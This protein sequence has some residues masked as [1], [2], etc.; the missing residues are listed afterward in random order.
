MDEA[1]LVTTLSELIALPSVGGTPAEAEIQHLLAERLTALGLAVDRWPIDLA[2]LRARP[3]FPGEE[4]ERTQAWGLVGMHRPQERPALIL[5]GHVDVVPPGDLSRWT[6]GPYA[7]TVR[8]GRVVGRGACDMKGGV[9]AILGAV[10]AALSSGA[11]V[12]PFAVHFVVGEEDG[13]L[14]AYATLARGH[15]GDACVIPEPTSLRLVTANAGSLTFRIDVPGQATH[16]STRYEGH[17]AIDAYLPI[18]SALAALEQ[19]R[20]AHPEPPLRDYP[21][22]YPLSVGRLQAGDW[23]SSVPDRL[24][25]EGRYG[26]RIGEDPAAA[27]AELEAAVAE[28]AAGEPYLREHPPRVTWPGGVFRGGQ[29]PP[30][31]SLEAPV[32][33]AHRQVT[34]RD[35]GPARGV[36][37]GSDLRLYAGAGIPTLHYGPGSP[38]EAHGPDEW[39]PIDELVT[40]AEVL[41]RLLRSRY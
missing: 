27:R 5:Q 17:S 30:G 8:D 26:V 11:E 41:T 34:G 16:G 28:A 19:R 1:G 13:G 35:I 23:P 9:A 12:P 15:T 38:R 22:A 25:A 39:V 21:I 18:H 33:D 7:P 20:N 2:G 31:S 36:S 32:G 29:L 24:V 4:V 6:G 14:G 3:D 37:Y 40:T 10:E